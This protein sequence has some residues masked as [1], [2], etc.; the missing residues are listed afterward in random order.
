MPV[1]T[2]LLWGFHWLGNYQS[3]RYL[4]SKNHKSGHMSGTETPAWV[5]VHYD[6]KIELSYLFWIKYGRG[7]TK[8]SLWIIFIHFHWIVN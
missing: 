6:I 4:M 2:E 3:Y 5:N 8:T 1:I 7:G